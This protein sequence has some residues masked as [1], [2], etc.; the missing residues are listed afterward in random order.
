M[1]LIIGSSPALMQLMQYVLESTNKNPALLCDNDFFIVPI[2]LSPQNNISTVVM[3]KF[4][5]TV[6]DMWLLRS[7]CMSLFVL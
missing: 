6:F 2:F 3:V 7:T 5:F 1:L 4:W